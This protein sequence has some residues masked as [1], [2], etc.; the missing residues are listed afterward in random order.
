MALICVINFNLTERIISQMI[1]V[2]QVE[3]CIDHTKLY[4]PHLPGYM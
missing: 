1:L 2:A 3:I 4:H